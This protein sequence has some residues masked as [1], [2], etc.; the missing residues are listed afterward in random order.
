MP[1][2]IEEVAK[3]KRSVEGLKESAFWLGNRSMINLLTSTE[4]VHFGAK[5]PEYYTPY[6]PL[7]Q[8]MFVHKKVEEPIVVNLPFE[9]RGISETIF[10]G[11]YEFSSGKS[12]LSTYILS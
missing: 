1:K 12:M 2:S 10:V 11:V 7:D 8:R 9:V 4:N 6:Q 3:I 5:S